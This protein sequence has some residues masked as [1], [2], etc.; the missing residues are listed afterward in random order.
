MS[1]RYSVAEAKNHLPKLLREVEKGIEIEI[2]RRG[3]PVAVLISNRDFMQ[4]KSNKPKDSRNF[5]ERVQEIRNHPDFE[6]LSDEELEGLRDS[7]PGR[8][9]EL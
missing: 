2:T 3:E 8:E 9:V 5:W 1:Q 6:P 7:S 4:L